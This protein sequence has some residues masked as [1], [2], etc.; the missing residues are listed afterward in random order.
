MLASEALFDGA[1]FAH[2]VAYEERQRLARIE[3]RCRDAVA[4]E[5]RAVRR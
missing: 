1:H 3:R 5:R 4:R 2:V